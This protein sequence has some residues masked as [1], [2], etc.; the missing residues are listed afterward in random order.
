MSEDKIVTIKVGNMTGEISQDL[1]N[2]LMV[3]H[4]IDAVAELTK[5]LEEEIEKEKENGLDRISMS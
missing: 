2:D 3:V 1:I 5:I 4:G